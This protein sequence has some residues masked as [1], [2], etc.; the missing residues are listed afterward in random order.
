MRKSQLTQQV[1]DLEGDL[2]RLKVEK[3]TV[4]QER[5]LAQTRLAY[6][7]MLMRCAAHNLTTKV[8]KGKGVEP[9]DSEDYAKLAFRTRDGLAT[10]VIDVTTGKMV[11]S[12]SEPDSGVYPIT[13]SFDGDGR[14]DL[15]EVYAI[16]GLLG[17]VVVSRTLNLGPA[18]SVYLT[19]PP[20][21]AA[22]NVT[23][24][25]KAADDGEP[26]TA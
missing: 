25:D 11:V 1:E 23:H 6:A 19:A 17:R 10:M 7:L 4:T 3:N 24:L 16:H 22:T 12:D 5:D 9:I 2:Y 20:A 21:P 15:E 14:L 26:H 8:F 18:E 13:V